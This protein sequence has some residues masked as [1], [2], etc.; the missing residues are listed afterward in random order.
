V[1]TADTFADVVRRQM[2]AQGDKRAY[3]FLFD[4]TP[5][6]APVT[7]SFTELDLRARTIAAYLQDHGLQGERVLLLYPYGPHFIEAFLGCLY[8]G[9]VA[10]PAPL[11]TGPRHQLERVGGII[12]AADARLILTVSGAAAQIEATLTAVGL[13]L[14]CA[15]TDVDPVADAGAWR[16]P[17]I[18][19]DSLAFLQYTSGSTALPKGVMVSHANLVHNQALI[20]RAF[21]LSPDTPIGGWLPVY[22]DMGLIGQVLGPLSS[23]ASAALMS[24]TA[25]LRRPHRWLEMISRFRL[26]A[27]GGPNFCFDFCVRRVS[28]E[29]LAQLDLSSWT[30]AFNGAEPVRAAT[31]AAFA[32][33]FAP[34]GFRAEAFSPCYGMAEATLLVAAG[35][36]AA[37]LVRTVSS[38]LLERGT[39]VDAGPAD[40]RQPVV[41]S[42]RFHGL[43]VAVVDPD[44][45]RRQPDGTVGE[46]WV[47]G[48]SVARGYWRDAEATT[49]VFDAATADG[50]RG[51]LR[52]GDLGA[53][54]DGELFVTGRRKEVVVING[55]NL[56]PDDIETEARQAHPALAGRQTAAFSVDIGREHVVVVQEVRP[57]DV[58]G[59]DLAGVATAIRHRVAS[60]LGLRA[61]SVVLVRPGGVRRTTSG[62]IQRRLMRKLFVGRDLTP[63][64]EALEAEV[65]SAWSPSLCGLPHSRWPKAWIGT[66]ATRTTPAMCSRSRTA[67]PWTT[68]RRSR[69]RHAVHW[70]TGAS[71]TTTFRA[72]TAEPWPTMT[73]SCS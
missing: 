41:S 63:L 66:S 42:G 69:M 55:R 45:H 28:D 8:A 19:P 65:S 20:R 30:V 37:P 67:L 73:M 6:R 24:P 18:S 13:Q 47:R 12:A 53:S 14:P 32:E 2:A 11:P 5:E 25:F 43:D 57:D 34:A 38:P 46:I 70:R 61:P 49:E 72:R 58:R 52:T 27:S 10:V 17:D 48:D 54:A 21:R 64:H 71:R 7:Q 9:S 26:Y 16:R 36:R 31:M 50:V 40:R 44:T 15:D 29:Q 22:H 56:Y 33:R 62:K 1:R 51:W 60:S 35:A 39:L 23:G 68:V 4:E 3:A 59:H